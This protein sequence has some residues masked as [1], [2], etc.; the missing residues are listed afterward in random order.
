MYKPVDRYAVYECINTER[1]YQDER[2]PGHKH[3]ITE[4]LVYIKHYLDLAMTKRST[5]DDHIDQLNVHSQESSLNDLRK[6]AALAVACMEE[7]GCIDREYT[8][9]KE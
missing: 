6:I 4:Y 3:S 5:R 1:N 7:N 9:E 8:K 2:W